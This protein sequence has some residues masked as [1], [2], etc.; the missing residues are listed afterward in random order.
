MNPLLDF[1][2]EPLGDFAGVAAEGMGLVV[3]AVVAVLAGKA[4]QRGV[5]LHVHVI[6]V[7]VHGERRGGRV[8]HAEDHHRADLDRRAIAIV[9]LRGLAP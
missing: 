8:G 5:G 9:H 7:I 1:V 6:E 4:A 2:G 3:R